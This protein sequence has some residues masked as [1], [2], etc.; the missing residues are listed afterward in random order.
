MKAPRKPKEPDLDPGFE[1]MT[2]FTKLRNLGARTPPV[3]EL[4]AAW[5]SFFLYKLKTKQPVNS[6]QATQAMQV[7]Q[8]LRDEKEHTGSYILTYQHVSIGLQSLCRLPKEHDKQ[9]ELAKSLYGELVKRGE[10][11]VELEKLFPTLVDILCAGGDTETAYRMAQEKNQES[12]NVLLLVASGFAR[13]NNE[14]E[15]CKLA[16]KLEALGGSKWRKM[17]ALMIRFY[18]S[19]NDMEAVKRWVPRVEESD[20]LPGD[21]LR[22]VLDASIKTNELEWCKE[23]FRSIINDQPTKERWD[24]VLEWASGA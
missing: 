21:V 20:R 11:K 10:T 2:D 12:A 6:L 16:E 17:W 1:K 5:E 23:Y 13:E 24:V 4:V 8:H 9:L 3:Q 22:M 15:L 14:T 18:A 19:R 7:F